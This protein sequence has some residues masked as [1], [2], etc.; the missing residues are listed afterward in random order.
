MLEFSVTRNKKS[1]YAK[2][3]FKFV[4]FYNSIAFFSCKTGYLSSKA[5]TTKNIYIIV[6]TWKLAR[7]KPQLTEEKI[8][9]CFTGW[10]FI[11]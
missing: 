9:Y 10:T 5:D 6:G 7:V 4:W 2:F 1:M 3:R 8:L 11:L